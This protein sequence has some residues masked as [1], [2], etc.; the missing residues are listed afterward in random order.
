[1]GWASTHRQT[2]HPAHRTVDRR[3]RPSPRRRDHPGENTPKLRKIAAWAARGAYTLAAIADIDFIRTALDALDTGNP[4]PPPFGDNQD[5]WDAFHAD[6]T[7]HTDLIP[8]EDGTIVVPGGAHHAMY[9]INEA[10]NDDPLSAA[11]CSLDVAVRTDNQNYPALIAD[12]RAA[13][14]PTLIAADKYERWI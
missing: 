14:F 2:P 7:I 12:L 13:F 5:V 8:R 9:A 4:L 3:R 10:A 11:F 6:P 1:M